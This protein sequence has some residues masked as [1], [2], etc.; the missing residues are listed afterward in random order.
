MRLYSGNRMKKLRYIPIFLILLCSIAGYGRTVQNSLPVIY[1]RYD[2]LSRDVFNPATMTF[3]DGNETKSFDAQ[4]RHRGQSVSNYQKQSFAIKLVYAQGEKLDTALMDLRS[5]NYWILDGM[6]I[7]KAR[8]RNKVS[9]D[10]WLDF[11]AKPYYAADEP[12]VRNGS[13]E[14]FVEVYAND[15]YVGLYCLAERID[16]K[17]LKLKKIKDNELRG[18][19]YKSIHWGGSFFGATTAYDNSSALWMRYEYK[20][21]E[22]L[23][24]WSPLCQAFDFVHTSDHDAFVAQ[25][26]SYVDIPV[27]MDYFLFTTL[28][29]ARDNAGK[30]LYLSFYNLTKEK[31]LLITPWD[32]DHSWGRQ[33]NSTTEAADTE[34]RWGVDLY[35]RLRNELPGYEETLLQRYA[36]LRKNAFSL[37]AL[38]ARFAAYFRFFEQTGVGEREM[39]QWN[40]VDNISLDFA[41]E[42]QYLNQWIQERLVYTDSLFQYTESDA[43]PLVPA[44]FRPYKRLE[45]GQVV[46]YHSHGAYSITGNKLHD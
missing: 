13:E 26:A 12:E 28:L 41:E 32:I 9:M 22:E 33:Y 27:F 38:Q 18:A 14:R 17:Q 40:G 35:T 20:Y 11:S 16:R 46:I 25:I 24:D 37:D 45:N 3:V 44:D 8:M 23:I 21:P 6:A 39:A 1:L 10:L 29:S 4:I 31:R 19:L 15:A 30:N 43:V 42:E 5:D 34:V 2:E 7:D 36:E